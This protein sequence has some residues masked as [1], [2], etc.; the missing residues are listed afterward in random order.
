MNLLTWIQ[1]HGVDATLLYMVY[2]AIVNALP[3]ASAA[4]S[5]GYQFIYKVLSTLNMDFKTV[6]SKTPTQVQVDAEQGK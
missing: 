1:T 6:I 3:P 5:P 2:S 4:S